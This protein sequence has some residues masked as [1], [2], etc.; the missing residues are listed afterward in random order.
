MAS[1]SWMGVVQCQWR[2]VLSVGRACVWRPRCVLAPACVRRRHSERVGEL[3]LCW[4]VRAR[5]MFLAHAAMA[6][7]MNTFAVFPRPSRGL[8]PACWL[9]PRFCVNCNRAQSRHM[10]LYRS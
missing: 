2:R 3:L 10:H 6:P 9:L 1:V 7:L 8:V 5:V 4:H